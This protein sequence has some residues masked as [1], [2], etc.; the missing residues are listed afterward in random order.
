MQLAFVAYAGDCRLYGEVELDLDRLSDLLSVGDDYA[1]ENV[2]LESLADGHR[3]ALPELA[4]GCHDLCAVEALG[5]RGDPRRRI[6]T[7]LHRMQLRVGP[8]LVA[9]FLHTMPGADPLTAFVRRGP[10]VALTEATLAYSLAGEPQL[11][12]AAVILVNH[13]LV[14]WIRPVADEGRAFPNVPVKQSP[15]TRDLTWE[16]YTDSISC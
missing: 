11:H 6:R 5:S 1:L 2:V 7:R 15:G 8:Y 10:F 3:V 9:G 14:E 13:E 4:I 12:D 16:I